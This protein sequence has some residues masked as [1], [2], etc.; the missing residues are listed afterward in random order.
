MN[1]ERVM[2]D[3]KNENDDWNVVSTR[4]HHSCFVSFLL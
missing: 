2:F 1:R 3:E 4:W